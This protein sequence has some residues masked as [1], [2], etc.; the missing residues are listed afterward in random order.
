MGVEVV[1][2]GRLLAETLAVA[3][4]LA[5]VFRVTVCRHAHHATASPMTTVAVMTVMMIF[6][7]SR[8]MGCFLSLCSVPILLCQ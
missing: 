8:M 5:V 6:F 2:R 1:L 3:V 7:L 4:G